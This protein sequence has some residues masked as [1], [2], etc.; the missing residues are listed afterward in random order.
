MVECHHWLN[1]NEF[2]QTLGNGEAQESLMC[3]SPWGC[4]WLSE[5]Q[6]QWQISLSKYSYWHSLFCY[7]RHSSLF[8]R[9]SSHTVSFCMHAQ[10]LQSCTTL[11]YH[12]DCSP[13]DSSARGIL[14]ERILEWVAMPFS[15]DLPYPGIE[16]ASPKSP[17]SAGRILKNFLNYWCFSRH[18]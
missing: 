8:S 15:G 2:E 3:C 9:A 1:E 17:A 6:Q 18:M 13:P 5:K 10:S 4:K 14:P 16:S 12:M 7:W 11:C